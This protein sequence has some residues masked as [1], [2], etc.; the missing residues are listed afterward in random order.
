MALTGNP[1]YGIIMESYPFI[2][3]KLMKEDTPLLQRS[4][5]ELLYG[6]KSGGGVKFSRLIALINSAGGNTADSQEGMIDLDAKFSDGF[7]L[8]EGLKFV[9]GDGGSNLR[10]LLKDE[11]IVIGDLVFRN[12]VRKQFGEARR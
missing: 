9:M 11:A 12:I 8:K 3:R 5:Q 10:G 1:N 7:G 6:D 2:A 4:L